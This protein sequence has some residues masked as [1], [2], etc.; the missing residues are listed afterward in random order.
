M[1]CSWFDSLDYLFEMGEKN[2]LT[3]QVFTHCCLTSQLTNRQRK[4]SA[5]ARGGQ[6]FPDEPKPEA[7]LHFIVVV[8][9]ASKQPAFTG[10]KQQ[11]EKASKTSPGVF[12][13]S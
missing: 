3:L 1:G 2:K 13:V 12:L 5:A 4:R 9:S 10:L 11:K 8:V 7:F 6:L